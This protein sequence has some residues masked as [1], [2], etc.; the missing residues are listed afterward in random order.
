MNIN[1]CLELTLYQRY[2]ST[3]EVRNILHYVVQAVGTSEEEGLVNAF[4][5]GVLSDMRAVQSSAVTHYK[6]TVLN[7]TDGLSFADVILSPTQSG[8]LAGECLPPHDAWAFR[9]NRLSRTTRSGQFRVC[10]IPEGAQANGIAS[11]TITDDLATLA[12]SLADTLSDGV[13]GSYAPCIVRKTLAGGVDTINGVLSVE[14][15]AVSTQ[16]TRKFGR[17]V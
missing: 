4:I 12:D 11:A 16:N 5:A 9:K 15:T 1:D 7:L 3:V 17:G 6:M 13:G 14:Y 2:A 8:L 10:G